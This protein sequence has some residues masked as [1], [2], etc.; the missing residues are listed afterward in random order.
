[1]LLLYLL[2]SGGYLVCEEIAV[3]LRRDEPWQDRQPHRASYVWVAAPGRS[4]QAPL[5]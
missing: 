4:C 5:R 3:D 1:M 2:I